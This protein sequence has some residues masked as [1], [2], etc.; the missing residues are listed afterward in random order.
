MDESADYRL[1]SSEPLSRPGLF[2]VLYPI[3]PRFV[4]SFV[5]DLLDHFSPS[6]LTIYLLDLKWMGSE[7]V[8][9][10]FF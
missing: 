5:A 3:T 10:R 2:L 6:S 4:S 1:R 8:S 9:L 7:I